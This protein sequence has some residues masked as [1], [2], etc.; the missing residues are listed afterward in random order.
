MLISH[1]QPLWAKTYI[2]KQFVNVNNYDLNQE[3]GHSCFSSVGNSKLSENGF[4]ND[5]CTCCAN[6]LTCTYEYAAS[7]E[8]EH[9]HIK[10]PKYK[11]YN[12]SELQKNNR[13]TL[14]CVV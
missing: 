2:Y 14:Q 12:C 10:S 8:F 4:T 9:T 3:R 7:T 13:N 1:S 5:N 11:P 6:L